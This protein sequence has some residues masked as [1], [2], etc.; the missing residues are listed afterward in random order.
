LCSGYTIILIIDKVLFDTHAI[1]GDH[2]HEDEHDNSTNNRASMLRK[3]VTSILNRG[4][5]G[6]NGEY[7]AVAV[8]NALKKSMAGALR[9]SE[10]FAARMSIARGRENTDD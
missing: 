5:V 9:K 1:L 8:E 10:V 7:S 4:S 3:S 6:P 2:D